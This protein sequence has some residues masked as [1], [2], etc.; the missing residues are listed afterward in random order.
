MG[1]KSPPLGGLGEW[2]PE[3]DAEQNQIPLLYEFSFGVLNVTKGHK[4]ILLDE[5]F[6]TARQARVRQPRHPRVKELLLQAI[7]C[8]KRLDSC[9]SLTRTQLAFEIGI[10]PARLSQVLHLLDLPTDLQERIL[11]MD[12]MI[13]RPPLTERRLRELARSSSASRAPNKKSPPLS[14]KGPK[15]DLDKD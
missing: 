3:S 8:R 12:L 10:A 5:E 1:I 7:S 9:P 13:G 15:D 11:A 14:P 6:Q 2:L 4:Q